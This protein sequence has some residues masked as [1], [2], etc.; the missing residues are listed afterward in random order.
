MHVLAVVLVAVV[1]P[2]LLMGAL[3]GEFGAVAIFWG[4]VLR[5]VGAKLG[6]TRRMVVVA[7]VMGLAAG[8]GAF[9]A[10]DWWWVALLAAAAAVAVLGSGSGG[11]VPW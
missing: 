3:V 5:G 7:P 8:L 6:G 9:T 1:L 10:Y 11:S 4:I 2:A